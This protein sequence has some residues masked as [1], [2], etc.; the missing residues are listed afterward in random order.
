MIS[1]TTGGITTSSETGWRV[2]IRHTAQSSVDD[3]DLNKN[4]TNYRYNHKYKD[5][6]EI[7]LHFINIKY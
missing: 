3:L 7:K 6:V 2:N 4:T 5:A 1:S